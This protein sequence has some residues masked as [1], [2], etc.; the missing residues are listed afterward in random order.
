MF[1]IFFDHGRCFGRMQIFAEI[2]IVKCSINVYELNLVIVFNDDIIGA[3]SLVQKMQ[4][5][6]CKMKHK[7][8][9]HHSLRLQ[10][11]RIRE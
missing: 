8:D 3:S 11:M 5:A 2:F 7:R 4:N 1:R 10:K 9:V 6:K